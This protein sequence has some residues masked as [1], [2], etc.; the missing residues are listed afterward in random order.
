M[1]KIFLNRKAQGMLEY[2]TMIVFVS[3]AIIAMYT[4]MQRSVN[5]RLKEVQEELNEAK[6]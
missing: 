2:V 5:A 4:Y 1:K 3:A 6:R